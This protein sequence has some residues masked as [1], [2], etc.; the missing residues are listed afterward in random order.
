L[1]RVWVEK[2]K[3]GQGTLIKRKLMAKSGQMK[4]LE[5][6]FRRSEGQQKISF[7]IEKTNSVTRMGARIAKVCLHTP[8][9][10]VSVSRNYGE[11]KGQGLGKGRWWKGRPLEKS[12]KGKGGR[13][14]GKRKGD[15]WEGGARGKRTSMGGPPIHSSVFTAVG[16]Q[17]GKRKR[18]SGKGPRATTGV[19]SSRGFFL[20]KFRGGDKRKGKGRT[21]SGQKRATD[22]GDCHR[23]NIIGGWTV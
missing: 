17:Q 2:E 11:S 21:R 10:G 1:Q 22:G 9:Q 6:G 8:Q 16:P 4:T 3:R 18:A 20:P 15:G 12:R 7:L 5:A 14:L 23:E 13:S 19:K